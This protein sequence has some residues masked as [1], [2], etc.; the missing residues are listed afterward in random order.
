MYTQAHPLEFFLDHWYRFFIRLARARFSCT[1]NSLK[2]RHALGHSGVGIITIWM[3]VKALIK[4]G[5]VSTINNFLHERTLEPILW[6]WKVL[7][8][9]VDCGRWS[10]T[11]RD[12]ASVE[13]D[14]LFDY[15]LVRAHHDLLDCAN[16]LLCR[17]SGKG[18]LMLIRKLFAAAEKDVEL[19]KAL[20]KP[21]RRPSRWDEN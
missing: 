6:S 2:V 20:L 17:A 7:Y 9:I 4:E 12:I 8:H 1:V 18:C 19:R 3:A 13:W 16:D 15:L 10:G 11:L 21:D 14:Q 5:R